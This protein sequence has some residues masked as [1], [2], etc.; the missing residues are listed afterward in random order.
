[1]KNERMLIKEC[2]LN[3]SLLLNFAIVESQWLGSSQYWEIVVIDTLLLICDSSVNI[4]CTNLFLDIGSNDSMITVFRHFSQWASRVMIFLWM[5]RY[6]ASTSMS[7]WKRLPSSG[8]VKNSAIIPI[9]E[10]IFN[11]DFAAIT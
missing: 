8:F 1:M 9:W 6:T 2:Y 11:H 4:F 5:L 10:K 7:S 3:F